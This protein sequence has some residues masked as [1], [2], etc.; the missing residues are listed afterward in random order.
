LRYN[1]QPLQEPGDLAWQ[2][3]GAAEGVSVTLNLLR[4]GEPR[5]IVVALG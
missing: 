4:G 5:E 1:G 3:A 2:L